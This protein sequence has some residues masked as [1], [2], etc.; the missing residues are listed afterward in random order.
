MKNLLHEHERIRGL[1]FNRFH[2]KSVKALGLPYPSSS[3]DFGELLFR[4]KEPQ[5]N[6]GAQSSIKHLANPL[7]M[8]LGRGKQ[9]RPIAIPTSS[10]HVISES[11]FAFSLFPLF[12]SEG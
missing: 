1:G 2:P 4:F 8:L 11:R 9:H 3:F 7:A 6:E 10:F 5:Q 12:S